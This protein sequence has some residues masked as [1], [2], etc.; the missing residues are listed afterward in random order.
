MLKTIRSRRMPAT[1]TST[2]SRPY[3]AIAVAI[4]SSAAA[5]SET[6]A[7]LAIALPRPAAIWPT[8]CAAGPTSR[9]EPSSAAPRSLTTTAAP[10][11][12]RAMDT[13]LPMP[14]PAP[15]TIATRPSSRPMLPPPR[16]TRIVFWNYLLVTGPELSSGSGQGGADGER[17]G[18]QARRGNLAVGADQDHPADAAGRRARGLRRAGLRQREHRRHR[19]TGRLEC[20]QPVPP[21][22]RQERAVPRA[23][24]AASARSRASSQRGSR[25][26][27]QGRRDRPDRA[28]L[29]RRPGVPRGELGPPGPVDAVRVRRRS[30]GI[31][32][33]ATAQEPRVDQPER[34]A[35]PAG[36]HA[37][38]PALR[39]DP[40]LADRRGRP[41]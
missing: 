38:G 5:W 28:V 29:C 19:G 13:D 34:R 4:R 15:V 41:R 6:S 17:S 33:H 23:V 22:R 39:G 25:A 37:T 16:F 20:G 18:Q 27:A 10:S 24:A 2:S 26:G 3:S 8:T 36:R 7:P 40:D 11:A 14:R 1:L 31:R 12:A 21:L 35:A 32:A 9:P 30:A